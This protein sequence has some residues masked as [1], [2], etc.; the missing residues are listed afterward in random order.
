MEAKLAGCEIICDT[1]KKHEFA[2]SYFNTEIRRLTSSRCR[3]G[4]LKE[5]KQKT[6]FA[7]FDYRT[8]FHDGKTGS[9]STRACRAASA[10]QMR[11]LT[12]DGISA[13]LWK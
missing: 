2:C 5:K 4:T 3:G 11:R 7:M 13:D 1:L 10:K 6:S 9:C 12:A 8:T